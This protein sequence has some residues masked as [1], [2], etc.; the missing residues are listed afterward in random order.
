MDSWIK[1]IVKKHWK[2]IS[3]KKNVI[4]YSGKLQPRII[5]RT[6][7]VRSQELCFRIYIEE[8]DRNISKKDMV[9]RKLKIDGRN[10]GYYSSEITIETDLVT[11]GK[12]RALELCRNRDRPIKAGCSAMNYLGTAC[13]SGYFVKNRKKGEEEFIGIVSNNHCGARENKAKRGEPYLYPSPLDGGTLNDKVAI[14]WR[15]VDL[16]F[17]DYKCKYRNFLHK[18]KKL[19]FKSKPNKVDASLERVTIPLDK[20]SYSI[21]KIGPPKGKR[22][23]TIGEKAKKV[24][25]TTGLT[26]NAILT[27]NDWYG[28]V[29]YSRGT[30]FFGPCALFKGLNFSK[31]GDSSSTI[32]WEKD[33][34]IGALL[35]AGSNTHTIGC[36]YDLVEELLEVE[37]IVP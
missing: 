2:D 29:E 23:G 19:F 10:L 11:I 37:Y 32:V 22:R 36:H 24:G 35:F 27:D 9:P 4:G 15:H 14:H 1:E 18:I 25:R 13:T 30:A 12:I 31:G 21:F 5:E 16:Q 20:V 26:V 33:N 6:G 3:K 28:K 34:F 7:E 8:K 17:N